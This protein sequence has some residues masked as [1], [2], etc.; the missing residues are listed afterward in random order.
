MNMV[1]QSGR[2]LPPYGPFLLGGENI[3]QYTSATLGTTSDPDAFQ[4]QHGPSF[5]Y[6][7][8]F[9]FVQKKMSINKVQEFSWNISRCILC[10]RVPCVTRPQEA[11]E[12][13]HV[14]VLLGTMKREETKAPRK[15]TKKRRTGDLGAGATASRV[16]SD[17]LLFGV[18]PFLTGKNILRLK[19]CSKE[20]ASCVHGVLGKCLSPTR[21]P[22]FQ[23]MARTL[24]EVH[25]INKEFPKNN[26][27]LLT[28]TKQDSFGAFRY[29]VH[30][31]LAYYRQAH[32]PPTVLGLHRAWFTDKLSYGVQDHVGNLT[33][34][35]L[36][37]GDA[38]S[39]VSWEVFDSAR[40]LELCNAGWQEIINEADLSSVGSVHAVT[41]GRYT[42]ETLDDDPY[43]NFALWERH[44]DDSDGWG[45]FGPDDPSYSPTPPSY[46][47]MSPLV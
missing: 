7:F 16:Y 13:H 33:R 39:R 47:P 22:A 46:S 11:L 8:V 2:M 23:L 18:I 21:S 5:I 30:A 35:D 15:T 4:Y 36:H 20:S 9:F 25:K 31:T 19:V 10:C 26:G 38:S 24:E 1:M 40:C 3:S 34:E 41:P 29:L 45:E 43:Y 17:A 44:D 6:L 28:A 37:H 12:D 32:T 27:V 42:Y 14:P